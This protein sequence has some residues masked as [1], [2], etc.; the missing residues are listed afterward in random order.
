MNEIVRQRKM[1][2][3]IDETINGVN[4]GNW[5]VLEKWMDPAVFDESGEA[6]EIWIHCTTSCRTRVS[7]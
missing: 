7:I 5:L 3:G 4:L 2:L 6:D 1:A